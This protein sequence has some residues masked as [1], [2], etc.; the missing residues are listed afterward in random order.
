MIS[1]VDLLLVGENTIRTIRINCTKRWNHW[2]T[3][4]DS[5]SSHS[6]LWTA[7]ENYSAC[8]IGW[9]AFKRLCEQFWTP[10]K[11]SINGRAHMA[12]CLTVA[13]CVRAM[14]ILRKRNT[15]FQD[16]SCSFLWKWFIWFIHQRLS[17]FCRFLQFSVLLGPR[18]MHTKV[19]SQLNGLRACA[20]VTSSGC[21]TWLLVVSP[22]TWMAWNKSIWSFGDAQKMCFCNLY[23]CNAET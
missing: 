10:C 1:A 2:F 3:R 7:S 23:F 5:Q 8:W 15:V 13:W 21:A 19:Y 4:L 14:D 12:H 22:H 17:G 6:T 18:S 11:N 9:I 16:V 20:L